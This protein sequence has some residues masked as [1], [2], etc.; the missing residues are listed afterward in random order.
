MKEEIPIMINTETFSNPYFYMWTFVCMLQ[1]MVT[2]WA[3]LR[4]FSITVP[5]YFIYIFIVFGTSILPIAS[6]FFSGIAHV[7]SIIFGLAVPILLCTPFTKGSR[8]K[9]L[10]FFAVSLLLDSIVEA[11]LHIILYISD[12][13]IPITTYNYEKF[14]MA[15]FFLFAITPVKYVMAILWNK[16]I[17]KN[18]GEH[19]RLIFIVFPIAQI[20]AYTC[21]MFQNIYWQSNSFSSF[22]F[23]LAAMVIFALS[24]IMFLYFISDFEK[25]KALE[26]EIKA[27][28]YTRLLEEKHYESIEAKRYEA[29]KIRHD[30][31]NQISAMRELI[32]LGKIND[33]DG[34]IS[35]LE[36]DIDNT[37]E[38]EYC[39]IPIVNAVISEKSALC[40]I[41]NIRFEA[42]I[43]FQISEKIAKSHICCIFSNLLDNAINANLKIENT[44][45]RYI[46]IKGIL[47]NSYIIIGCKNPV[48]HEIEN[49]KLI[50]EQSSGYGLKILRDIALQYNGSFDIEIENSVCCASIAIDSDINTENGEKQNDF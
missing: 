15:I 43:C 41:N 40:K 28:E 34:I 21:M 47:K 10:I 11:I 29:A 16:I 26:Q 5:K 4:C 48:S 8:I 46:T 33:A 39:S 7:I 37:K 24:D 3:Y 6:R 20:L 42:D 49:I 22:Y 30:I 38:Y 50:P 14:I 2:A 32:Y 25:K 45:D 9:P 17:N 44:S 27:I 1:S 18:H 12:N 31:K 36:R 19:I 23:L 13:S 35:N